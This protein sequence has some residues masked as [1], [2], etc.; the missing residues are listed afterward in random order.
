[1]F[2]IYTDIEEVKL[3]LH[4]DTSNEDGLLVSLIESAENLC[5]DI[6]RININDFEIVPEIV[7]TAVLYAVAYLY[8][9]REQADFSELTN[10]LKNLLFGVRKEAF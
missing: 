3:Y 1:M 7:K 8:E 4:L 10:T 2:I 9:N 6:I 5:Q